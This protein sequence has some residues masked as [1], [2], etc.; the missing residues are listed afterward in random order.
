MTQAF[1]RHIFGAT[2]LIR[3]GQLHQATAV[4]QAA[5]GGLSLPQPASDEPAADAAPPSRAWHL[6][7]AP[8]TRLVQGL[9][10]L[11]GDL[12]GRTPRGEW[13]A[14]EVAPGH[15][16]AASFSGAAGTRPYKLYVP[17]TYAGGP[18][19]L[20]LMLHGCTQSP[21]DFAAGTRMNLL[22]EEAN[23]LVCYPAQTA[24]A[25]ASKCWNWFNAAEQRRDRGEP[26]LIAG[27]A[28]QIM[29]DYEVDPRRVYVA[30]LSAGGALAATMGELY[31]DLFAAIGVHSGLACGSAS[32]M[33]SAFTAMRRGG[34]RPRAGAAGLDD[35]ADGR[36]AVPAIVFH[37]DSDHTV[38]PSNGDDV[39][40][41]AMHSLAFEPTIERASVPGGRDYTRTLH[42]DE[43]GRTVLEQWTIVGAGHAWSG[44]S[45]AGT[46]TDPAGPDASREMLRFFLE[47]PRAEA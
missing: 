6:E 8:L 5:L 20:V 44:G 28:R 15:F 43:Q 2:D 3:S 12:L 36:G 27:I 14:G 29:A 35:E 40:A 9:K 30:G 4:L 13:T 23:C 39:I 26:S 45:A 31:P 21:D 47:H 11:P 19:P 16:L 41:Q 10:G 25:N 33:G 46:Y 7:P 37:G 42:R 38:H 24:A 34:Y 1:R 22:A 32:D 18:V 17:S